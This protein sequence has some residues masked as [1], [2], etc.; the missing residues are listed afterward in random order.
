MDRHARQSK[1][2]EVGAIGQG[3][4]AEARVDVRLE[5]LAADIAARYL[6]G[7]GV[8]GLR[9]REARDVE[10]ARAL[11][12][13]LSVDVDPGLSVDSAGPSFGLRDATCAEFARGAYAALLALRTALREDAG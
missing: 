13:G 1:L 4:I 3:R 10:G 5:G 6:A 9:V 11:V 7:A 12:P 8:A 2:A